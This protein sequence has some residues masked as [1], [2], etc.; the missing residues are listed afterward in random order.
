[1]L[2][3]VS[4]PQRRPTAAQVALQWR[5]AFYDIFDKDTAVIQDPDFEV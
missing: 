5:N 1:M 3:K 2:C 4:E